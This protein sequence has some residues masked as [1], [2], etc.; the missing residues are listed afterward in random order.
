[1]EIDWDYAQTADWWTLEQ[2]CEFVCPDD[3]SARAKLYRLARLAIQA[4]TL[5]P[6]GLGVDP[7]L[8]LESI[9]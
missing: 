2:F 3:P 7:P 8:R 9:G 5:V 6:K 1:M 4:G